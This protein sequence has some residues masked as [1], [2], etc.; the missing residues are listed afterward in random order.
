MS[1]GAGN[2]SYSYV[3]AIMTRATYTVPRAIVMTLAITLT[4]GC[5][6]RTAIKTANKITGTAV[7]TTGA[8]VVGT[9]RA[10]TFSETGIR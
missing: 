3:R 6:A 10:V 9:A 2:H 5:P 1:F 4:A 8:L 7:R